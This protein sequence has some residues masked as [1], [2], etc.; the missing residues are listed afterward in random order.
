[1]KFSHSKLILGVLLLLSLPTFASG[2]RRDPLTEAEADQ[3]REASDKPEKR[4][5]L[6]I[7]FAKARLSTIDQLRSD[8]KM[9]QGRGQ[10]IHDLLEDFA[11]PLHHRVRCFVHAT[12]L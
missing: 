6:Y 11:R 3:I 10:Q 4:F 5:H 1:M 12:R 9:V 8:P 2:R 7:T